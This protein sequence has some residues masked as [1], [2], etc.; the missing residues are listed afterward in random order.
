M[1]RGGQRARPRDASAVAIPAEW[2]ADL[3]GSGEA[4]SSL[5][6]GG[7]LSMAASWSEQAAILRAVAAALA[8]APA[9]AV[10]EALGAGARFLAR[11]LLNPGA[12]EPV[13]RSAGSAAAALATH[14]PALV[15]RALAT[16]WRE[17]LASWPADIAMLRLRVA[18]IFDLVAVVL[19]G[20]AVLAGGM[21]MAGPWVAES[22]A[23]VLHTLLPTIDQSLESVTGRRITHTH[24]QKKKKNKRAGSGMCFLLFSRGFSFLT[25]F[26]RPRSLHACPPSAASGVRL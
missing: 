4:Q 19:D 14:H 11:M 1:P 2:L 26:S 6:D 13:R 17:L 15:R 5:L 25:P 21:R 12:S 22:M 24:T 7:A 10:S 23:S 8:S 18:Q 9:P 3:S 20:S 16:V